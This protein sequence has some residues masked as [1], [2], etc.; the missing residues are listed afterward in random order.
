MGLF[1]EKKKMWARLG[2]GGGSR[3]EKEIIMWARLWKMVLYKE[4][5]RH[6]ERK[7]N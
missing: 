3:L 6:I 7:Q 4:R 5:D 1:E 2:G